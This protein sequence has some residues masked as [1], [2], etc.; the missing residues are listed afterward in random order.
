MGLYHSTAIP[1][2]EELEEYLK[3]AQDAAREA[4]KV[5]VGAWNE[6]KN[7]EKK[8]GALFII[9]VLQQLSLI[10]F[11]IAY[12]LLLLSHNENKPTGI[13]DLVTET[14]KNCEE[15]IRKTLLAA[16]PSHAF[17]GEEGSAEKGGIPELTDAPT[18][19][20]DPIDGTTNFV[21]RFPFSCVSIALVMDENVVVG[22]VYNPIL[23]EMFHAVRGGGAFVNGASIKVSDTETLQ[24][25]LFATELGTRRDDAF[26]DAAFGRMR[27]ISK[28]TRSVRACGSCA[29]N[30]CS[31][32][33]GR[34]DFYYEAGLGGPWDMAAAALILEEAGGKV[35]DPQGGEFNLLSRRVL[36]ANA[37]L[38]E[39]VSSILDKEELWA[40]DEPK[41]IPLE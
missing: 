36:G 33:M 31:V 9:C 3:V 27:A 13:M 2:P 20:V 16:Y 29:L 11:G 4:G 30:L 38:G 22:V 5:I 7:I 24:D 17:I 32:A 23:D 26:L 10:N 6:T 14:D 21:H 1:P 18:W 40:P 25:A 35:L 39:L 19:M 37:H 15:L 34:L 12:S 28:E 41:A 8:S